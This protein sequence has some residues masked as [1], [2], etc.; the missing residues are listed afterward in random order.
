[1]RL[2]H[3]FDSDVDGG[4]GLLALIVRISSE[5]V[6][7]PGVN[8]ITDPALEVQFGT[9]AHP[10]GHVIQPHIHCINKVNQFQRAKEVLIVRRGRMRAH[11]FT[12]SRRPVATRI[13]GPGD[14]VLLLRGGHGFEVLEPVEV[15]EVRLGEWRAD[16]KQRFSLND[17]TAVIEASKATGG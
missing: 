9:I 7:P 8:F 5:E 13:V 1:M 3:V 12:T 11:F 4:E 15:Y 6:F 2:D 10:A 17:P 16:D 14:V